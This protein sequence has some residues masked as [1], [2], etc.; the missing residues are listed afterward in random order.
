[1]WPVHG[2]PPVFQAVTIL[3]VGAVFVAGSFY[4]FLVVIDRL[5]KK[6]TVENLPAFVRLLVKGGY[7]N[8]KM[9]VHP[10]GHKCRIEMKKT[11]DDEGH[12][13]YP[14]EVHLFSSGS[15][16][17]ER[18]QRVLEKQSTFESGIKRIARGS[19]CFVCRN[20][21]PALNRTMRIILKEGLGLDDQARLRIVFFGC[22]IARSE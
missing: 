11:Y 3:I 20:D 21:L 12:E 14:T 15:I 16:T 6:T 9:R 22:V 10:Q 19:I 2:L 18:I 1:M 5:G 13:Q 4:A 8:S 7:P 17:T